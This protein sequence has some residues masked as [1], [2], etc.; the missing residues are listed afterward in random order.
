[1][2]STDATTRDIAITGMAFRFPGKAAT[3]EQYWALLNSGRSAI[4]ETPADRFDMAQYYSTDPDE[5]GTT[6]SRRAGYV[7]R[8]YDFDPAF[9][10]ISQAEALSMDPQQRWLLELCWTAL[11]NAGIRP[12]ELRGRSV[13]MYLTTGEVDYG[14]RTVWSQDLHK[15]TTYARLGTNHGISAGRVAY[16]LGVHG[17]AMFVD[18]ACSSSLTAVHLAAQGLLTGDCDIAIAGG[19]NLILGPE[20]TISMA[21]LK[22]M[23]RTETC[24]PF[25]AAADGYMRGEGGGVIVMRRLSDAVKAGD[26]IDAVLHGSAINND[27][28]SN[29]LTAPNGTAQVQVI[30]QAL[31]RAHASP[32]QVAYVE[33]HG[34]GTPLGDPIE[35][36]ALRNA[37]T[38]DI[39]RRAPLLIGS[40]KAQVGHLEV[41]AGIAGLIKAVLIL[42]HRVIPAQVNFAS[43]NPRFKWDGSQIDVSRERVD[44]TGTDT[45]VG[46]SG[47]GISGTNAHLILGGHHA[48][49]T[50][51]PSAH[52]HVLTLSAR[53]ADA[54][55]RLVNA[56]RERLAD[57]RLSVR[58]LCFTASVRRDHWSHRLA[59]VGNTRDDFLRALDDFVVE[60][61][62]GTWHATD[63]VA[64]RR[65]AFLFPGQGA[66]KPGIGAGLYRDNP[67]FHRYVD[68]C[69]SLLDA[70][71]A[72]A[73]LL[74]IK[75]EHPE[76][77]RHSPG[78]LGHF[79]VLYSL[80]RTWMEL[81]HQ[82]DVVI[83]HS[84]GEHAAAVIAG[85]MS[86]EDGLRVIAARGHLFETATPPGAMLAVSASV[87]ELSSLFQLGSDLFVA[88]INGPEQTVLSGTQ[89]A[90][91]AA[92]TRMV[93]MGRRVS[94][95]NTYDT[96]GHSPLLRT[97]RA[98]FAAALADV[99]MAP[100]GIAL[101]STLTGTL[102][103]E[104]IARPEHWLDLVEEPVLFSQ[105][106]NEALQH[107]TVFL[108][109][110]PGA[111]L[112]N[113]A[114]H[115][116]QDWSCAISSL[117]DTPDGDES[118]ES[119][120]FAHACAR[121]YCAGFMQDW[122]AL[123][124]SPPVPVEA[125]TYPFERVHLELPVPAAAARQHSGN[126]PFSELEQAAQEGA[127]DQ[128]PAS[129]RAESAASDMADTVAAIR[130]LARSVA[131]SSVVLD[132]HTP[133]T[134]LGFDSLSLT[135]LR[136]RLQQTF[137]R[138]LAV[139][140][141]AKGV[142]ITGLARYFAG[143]SARE[144]APVTV[145]RE[146]RGEIV[147]LVHPVGGDVLC[148]R[149]FAD[150]WPGDPTIVALRH[151]EID[152]ASLSR[153][154][155]LNELAR[156]YIEALDKTLGRLPDRLGGWSLGGLIALEMAAEWEAAG[157]LAP[158]LMIVDSPLHDTGFVATVRNIVHR[159]GAH[160]S[161]SIVDELE[162]DTEFRHAL[163]QDLGLAAVRERVDAS[164]FSRISRLHT[165]NVLAMVLQR[166]P[167]LIAPIHY[168]LA[169]RGAAR[170]ST[171]QAAMHLHDLT[172]GPIDIA[173]FNDDHESIMQMP[174]VN[175][176]VTA[177][178]QTRRR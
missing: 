135:E 5:L 75:G 133:L 74:A 150:V 166:L 156:H 34:T 152:A 90:V 65:L 167:R 132:D 105:A 175:L 94:R 119:T 103:N 115:A 49:P 63:K 89:E 21:R 18:T 158:P 10:R 86:L 38:L 28:P 163:D 153:V 60:N 147:A 113:L 56:Y 35:L 108:E 6:Y 159:V 96:P 46:I 47:F 44:L 43:H 117:A 136:L 111:A 145:L 16:F 68:Q 70:P 73:V 87:D 155:T 42:K 172:A 110:G 107:D 121:L 23:S 146:G 164:T 139:S 127:E 95:L 27:G 78:Q 50:V 13:G 77:V 72:Q 171:E 82:P 29:G 142:S 176:L 79:V 104:D 30:E 55:A 67:I 128:E 45:L 58:D 40:V 69:L 32:E 130:D 61:P 66:W 169:E 54:R 114:R 151:P 157:H 51:E 124:P 24:R 1:M 3:A 162:R 118:P 26:R 168:A 81:G 93:D 154:W 131:S 41:A 8:P 57:G 9:F 15:I 112:S 39:Q 12:S 129:A 144:S 25:D 173:S 2:D 165:A 33:A 83:G 126:D 143:T 100:P 141:L 98:G 122:S 116:T 19:V 161:L 80:A 137:G 88:G 170:C 71:T 123:Y 20:E 120:G 85:V 149:E 125:P 4:D 148:Y 92:Y 174:S 59:L 36:S 109:V 31:K 101:I 53:S 140:M 52:A 62:S 11:E 64:K 48:A 22:A 84:L 134:V 99:K 14:R 178:S 102:A 7:E 106:L 37:Y 76:P 160:A 97:M 138:S 91:A 17:P 177:L